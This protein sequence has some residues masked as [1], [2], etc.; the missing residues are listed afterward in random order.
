MLREE[1]ALF[2]CS[3]L[4]LTKNVIIGQYKTALT[5]L[6]PGL[7]RLHATPLQYRVI[8]S[9]LLTLHVIYVRIYCTL[10]IWTM[11]FFQISCCNW[12][13][14]I[15]WISICEDGE[16]RWFQSFDHTL[17]I[18]H[19][20]SLNAPLPCYLFLWTWV[21]DP[22]KAFL[23]HPTSVSLIFQAPC[24]LEYPESMF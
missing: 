7:E 17:F 16:W 2:L 10:S 23:F 6:S 3:L 11:N 24:C 19:H 20:V 12:K 21:M 5:V 9:L 18:S 8:C 15:P 13:R 14:I 22:K 4:L 1:G